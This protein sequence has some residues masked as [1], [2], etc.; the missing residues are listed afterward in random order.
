MGISAHAPAN[1][2][3]EFFEGLSVQRWLE[4]VPQEHTE[5]EADRIDAALAAPAGAEILDVPCGG[6]R[7]SRAL[8]A[9]GYGGAGG[10]SSREFLAH[11]AACRRVRL[12]LAVRRRMPSAGARGA[13]LPGARCGLVARVPGPRGG[14]ARHGD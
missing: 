13:G 12:R 4:A 3:E 1:W 11:A 6:G 7:L 9:R 2:W 5:R 8:A 14:G 10:D